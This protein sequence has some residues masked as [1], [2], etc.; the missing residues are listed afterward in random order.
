[1]CS[2]IFPFRKTKRNKLILVDKELC[3]SVTNMVVKDEKI[4]ITVKL[5]AENTKNLDALIVYTWKY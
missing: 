1:M 3:H 5:Y 2:H 4:K